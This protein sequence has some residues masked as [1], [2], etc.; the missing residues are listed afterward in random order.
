MLFFQYSFMLYV[1]KITKKIYLEHFSNE[2]QKVE[3]NIL[4][5]FYLF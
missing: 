4:N 1:P 5:K 3:I 2:K